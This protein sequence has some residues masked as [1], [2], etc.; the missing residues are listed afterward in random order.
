[1]TRLKQQKKNLNR[2]SFIA[3]AIFC[4]ISLLLTIELEI[5]ERKTEK[6]G[7]ANIP[8]GIFI[9]ELV[10][11]ILLGLFEIGIGI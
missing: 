2:L 6:Y 7:A 8:K 9:N 1:L 11:T 3:Q 5:L 10:L 4:L